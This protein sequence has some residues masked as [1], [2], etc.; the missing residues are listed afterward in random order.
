MLYCLNFMNKKEFYYSNIF[1]IYKQNNLL[2]IIGPLGESQIIL[3]KKVVILFGKNKKGVPKLIFY[4]LGDV[5]KK[6]YNFIYSKLSNNFLSLIFG[7]SCKLFLK[8]IGFRFNLLEDNILALKIGFSNLVYQHYPKKVKIFFLDN[9]TIFLYS[10]DFDFLQQFS[11]S[12]KLLKRP[13]KYKGKGI[14]IK[15][16]L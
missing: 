10:M 14:Y 8:G 6:L 4:F 1:S 2:K 12:I 3:P 11:S 7:F 9:S 16:A 5:D 15:D 13:D